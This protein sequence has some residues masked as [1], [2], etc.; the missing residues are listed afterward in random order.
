MEVIYEGNNLEH[1]IHTRCRTK[2]RFAELMNV[3]KPT[4]TLWCDNVHF[5]TVPNLRLAC[6]ILK[7]EPWD[8]YKYKVVDPRKQ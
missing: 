7:C 4:V 8:I 2:A 6:A 1:L 5:M 3:S